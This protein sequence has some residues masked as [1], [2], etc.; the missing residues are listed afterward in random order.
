MPVY[1][2]VDVSINDPV[3]YE[4]YK[5]LRQSCAHTEMLLIEGPAFDPAR[6]G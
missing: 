1:V 2:A 5:A 6:T 4:R 3:T